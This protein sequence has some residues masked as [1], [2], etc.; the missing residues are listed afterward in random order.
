MGCIAW[1]FIGAFVGLLP[2]LGGSMSDWMEHM[3][4]LLPRI[5]TKSL[6]DGNIKG[7]IGPEGANNAQNNVNDSHCVVCIPTHHL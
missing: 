6:I 2:G 3:D 7:V 5:L 1:W 4:Q